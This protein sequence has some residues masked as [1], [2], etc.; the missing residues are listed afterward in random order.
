MTKSCP[1]VQAAAAGSSQTTMG[2]DGSLFVYEADRVRDRMEKFV[3]QETLS[4]DHFDNKRMTALIQETLQPRYTHVSRMTLRRDCM[5]MWKMAK[6]EMILGFQALK[7]GVNL[8]SDV[9]T[10][11]S[12]S[13]DAYLCVTAH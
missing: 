12:G 1:V 3:I 6:D 11:P 7:I 10:A 13:P 2:V 5:K 9:W 4:F 8:T